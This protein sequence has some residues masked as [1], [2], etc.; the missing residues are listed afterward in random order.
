MP[1]PYS[2]VILFSP[3]EQV[4]HYHVPDGAQ[5]TLVPKTH[6]QKN[7]FVRQVHGESNVSV[8]ISH[9]ICY[10]IL[11]IIAVWSAVYLTLLHFYKHFRYFS[12]VLCLNDL[13]KSLNYTNSLE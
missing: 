12:M 2:C 9:G 7:Q 13:V 3:G 5:M 8:R 11:V 1:N 10:L 6:N 4:A